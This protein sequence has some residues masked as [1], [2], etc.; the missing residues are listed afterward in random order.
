MFL[1]GEL[2]G[3][4][5]RVQGWPEAVGRMGPTGGRDCWS[6]TMIAGNERSQFPGQHCIDVVPLG[7]SLLV[8]NFTS[9]G[10]GQVAA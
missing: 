4:R 2:P 10:T 7:A 9:N 8:K 3:I 6:H 1:E 5:L